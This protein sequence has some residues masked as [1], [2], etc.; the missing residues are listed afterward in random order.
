MGN[1]TLGLDLGTNSVGWALIEYDEHQRPQQLIDCGARIFQEAVDLKTR[2]P[3]NQKRRAARAARRQTSRRRRR[4]EKLLNLLVR[5]GLLPSE[6]QTEPRLEILFNNLGNPY[7]LRKKAL[8][9]GLSPHEFGRAL[10]HLCHR[11]GFVSNRKTASKEDGKVKSAISNL[12]KRIGETGSRTLGEYLAHQPKKRGEYTSRSM[13]EHEFELLWQSQQ[14]FHPQ[15]LT[16]PLKAAVHN[17]IFHQRPLKLQKNLIGKCQFEPKRKRA[18]KAWLEAQRFRLLQD[19][20]HLQ[21]KSPMTREYR[22]LFP[23]E[24]NSLRDILERQQTLS[25]DKARKLLGR[26]SGEVFNLEE[27]RKT[28]LIGNRTTYR[29][30]KILSEPW[31]EM[32]SEQQSELITDMLTIDDEQAFIK[33]ALN[34]WKFDPQTAE[35]LAKTELEPGFLRLSLKAIRKILPHLEQGMTYDKACAAAGYNHSDQSNEATVDHLGEPANLRNPVVQKALYETRKVVNAVVRK[36]GKPSVI[37]IEMAR[38]MKLTRRQR[39]EVM[40]VQNQRKKENDL[41]KKILRED[42]GIQ[43]P[44]RSDIQKYNL[45]KECKETCPYTGTPISPAM[46]FSAEVDVEH[47]LPYGQWPDDSYMNKTLCMAVENRKHK[48]NRSP[49]EA[50]HAD[51]RKYQDILQRA[52]DLPWSKRRRFEQKEIKT[53]DFISRQLNDTRYICVEVRKY[54]AQLIGFNNV[55]VS[56]GE[57]TAALRH[58]WNLNRILAVDGVLEKNRGDHRHHAVDAVVIA[59][60][61]RVL[62]QKLSRLSAQSGVALSDRGFQLDEPWPDFYHS[63]AN[64]IDH[65][66]VSHAPTRKIADALHEETAYGY[67]IHDKCFVRRKPLDGNVTANEIAH[68]RDKK[69]KELVEA[70]LNQHDGNIKKAF[71]NADN[72]LLHVDGKTPIHTV[73][74]TAN[75]EPTTMLGIQDKTGT[76]YK[77]F[78]FGNNHHVEI[79]ESTATGKRDCHF[80]NAFEAAKRARRDKTPVTQRDFGPEW[81]SVMSLTVNDIVEV[82]CEEKPVLYRVQSMASGKQIEIVLKKPND[83]AS[84]RNTSTLR[85]RSS[86]DTQRVIRKLTLDALGQLS[87]AK[88]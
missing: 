39:E 42:F 13:Y 35:E 56:K 22:S 17:T 88:G 86:K 2:A 64:H 46:L 84:E 12:A 21:I 51:E 36:H 15:V 66:I 32:T 65:V 72:P 20:N 49:Y 26:H 30:R 7:Q 5:N 28:E 16:S 27:G 76:A 38:D 61:G 70:R 73:R 80:V 6:A 24:R 37:R 55:Q 58:H 69:I 79:V 83:A 25:W 75:F 87:L 82:E 47:I 44:T 40:K 48:H 18:A 14:R 1:V 9:E 41:A 60:T 45:W 71:G 59:L 57:A 78:K 50:Y 31:D 34:H 19:I 3:K 63:V 81:K 67:S 74:L 10:V 52:R 23:E 54:L 4:R 85:I 11:R 29:L 68:I 77:F 53:D 62:F 8:D 43:E 33:R